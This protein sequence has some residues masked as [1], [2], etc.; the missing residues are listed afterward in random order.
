MAQL[1]QD[2]A[3]DRSGPRFV[4]G[5]DYGTTY[6]GKLYY[7]TAFFFFFIHPIPSG[8][9][10]PKVP[11][12]I[13]YTGNRGEQWGYGIGDDA[14][15]ISWT[16]MKLEKPLSLLQAIEALWQTL[17]PA[18]QLAADPRNASGNQIQRHL[19]K[20]SADI[21]TDYLAKVATAVR[22]D[23]GN[24]RDEEVLRRFP[25]D[26]VTT[27]PV[28]WDARARNT[29]FRAVSKTFTKEFEMH[30]LPPGYI[31]LATESEACAQYTMNDRAVDDLRKGDCFIVVDA[32]GG[33]VDLVSYKVDAISPN[34]TPTRVTNVSS[35]YGAPIIDRYFLNTFLKQRFG[36][37]D[38]QKL[39][40]LRDQDG[41]YRSSEHTVLRRGEKIMSDRFQPIKKSFKGKPRHG[42]SPSSYHIDLPDGIGEQDDR[43]RGIL[44]GRMAIT[45]GD[46]EEMFKESVEGTLGLIREQIV[47]ID[48]EGLN[49]KCLFLSGGFSLNEYLYRKVSDLAREFQFRVVRGNDSWTAVAKGATL[50]GLGI[51]CEKPPPN[52]SA[53]C[54]IGVVLAERFAGYFH[55]ESQRYNDSFDDIL[56]A[57]DN[58]KWVVARGDLVTP[59]EGIAKKVDIAGRVRVILSCHDGIGEN[60]NR[61]DGLLAVRDVT[62]EIVKLDYDLE[63]IPDA[64]WSN[65][66]KHIIDPQTRQSCYKVEM[67]LE[68]T[69]SMADDIE[70]DLRAG[71][72]KDYYGDAN[73]TGYPL[74]HW[75]KL[76]T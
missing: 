66:C 39:L 8:V 49:V 67:Q 55:E 4:I 15:V 71:A 73:M 48:L 11:S 69:V 20:T 72:T 64:G 22:Q 54:H 59:R 75:R 9:Q 10:E 30:K 53:P 68:V 12:E 44:N 45:N 35:T 70:L 76:R 31:R 18:E 63:N 60:L 57:K 37:P 41:E 21:L 58:I 26:L 3:H 43:V 1:P 25:I 40:V 24:K 34:F 2:I 47:S 27:H 42:E 6:T 74:A 5:I 65:C 62:R 23:I 17:A 50:M 33:T 52:S 32:G 56:R 13:A 16:K 51:G 61:L 46:L 7:L 28:G 38:Y 14:Y 29:T 36:A 19:T